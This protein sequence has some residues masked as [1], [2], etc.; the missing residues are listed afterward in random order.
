MGGSINGCGG[1]RDSL[2][3]NGGSSVAL[4][5]TAEDDEK[6]TSKGLIQEGVEKGVQSRIDIA[7]P[8][9]SGPH[10]PGD[11]VV[12]E[13]I[14]NIS[15]KEWSPAEAEATH[16]DAQGLGCFGLGPHAMSA[17]LVCRLGSA[18]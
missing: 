3:Q 12:Y 13:G 6:G 2:A 7:E 15:D 10:L 9:E 17:M 5:I 18:L 1:A 16:D 4:I 11:S 8:E 14:H